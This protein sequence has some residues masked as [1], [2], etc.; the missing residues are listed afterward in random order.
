M[1]KSLS[2]DSRSLAGNR[3]LSEHSPF[4][5]VLS[6]VASVTLTHPHISLSAQPPSSL[7]TRH[8]ITLPKKPCIP[9]SARDYRREADDCG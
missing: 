3:D 6:F 7:T 1:T 2:R 9:V 4:Y 8:D 5:S